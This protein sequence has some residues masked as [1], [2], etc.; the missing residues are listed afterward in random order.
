M[1]IP[2]KHE[3]AGAHQRPRHQLIELGETE[4]AR[5]RPVRDLVRLGVPHTVRLSAS[6]NIRNSLL[7]AEWPRYGAPAVDLVV[8]WAIEVAVVDSSTAMVGASPS[9]RA[10][11]G[12]PGIAPAE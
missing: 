7:I 5:E 3:A 4:N 9:L 6:F 11:S 2:N 12:H 8:F 10:G 1:I